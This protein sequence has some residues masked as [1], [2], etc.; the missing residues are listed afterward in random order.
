MEDNLLVP[1]INPDNAPAM[2]PQKRASI[3]RKKNAAAKVEAP[4]VIKKINQE[5]VQ[6]LTLE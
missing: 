2:T 6:Q 4:A 5:D 3:T 1:Q